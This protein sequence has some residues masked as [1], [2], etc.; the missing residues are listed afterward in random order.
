MEPTLERDPSLAGDIYALAAPRDTD[1]F[2]IASNSGI[3]GSVVEMARIVRDH[4]HRLIAITS[5]GHSRQVASRHPSG[6][7]LY[8]L[9]DVVI[10]T[11]TPLG[12]AGLPIGDAIVVG[13]TSSLVGVTAV[14]MITEGVCRRLLDRGRTPPV[15]RSMNVPGS[16]QANAALEAHYRGRVRPIEP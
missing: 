5:L 13:A 4:G 7:K 8:E 3:N 2:L 6:A 14:Q 16:D 10:D 15:Y 12:D 1:C 11:G 9:A